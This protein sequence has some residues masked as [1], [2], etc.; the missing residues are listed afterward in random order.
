MQEKTKYL[1]WC[2]VFSPSYRSFRK[3]H[4]D[5]FQ[6]SPFLGRNIITVP[7]KNGGRWYGWLTSEETSCNNASINCFNYSVDNSIL[8]AESNACGIIYIPIIEITFENYNIHVLHDL[9]KWYIYRLINISSW[10]IV[11][12]IGH[13]HMGYTQW[14]VHSPG[15]RDDTIYLQDS[16]TV[17][18][19]LG[20]RTLT[21]TTMRQGAWLV[22]VYSNT[23]S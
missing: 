7:V 23:E 5:E 16:V 10:K 13:D 3:C 6:P 4:L 1:I 18:I 22:V 21:C 9:P 8:Y 2:R 17:P 12:K 19:K 15:K 20:F 14:Q 11:E